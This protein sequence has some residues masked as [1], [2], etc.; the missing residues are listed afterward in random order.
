MRGIISVQV[1]NRLKEG[2]FEVLEIQGWVSSP[3]NDTL[4]VAVT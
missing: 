4:L 2:D 3:G 1:S